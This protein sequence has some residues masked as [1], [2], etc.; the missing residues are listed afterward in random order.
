ME[1]VLSTLEKFYQTVQEKKLTPDEASELVDE[2]CRDKPLSPYSFVDNNLYSWSIQL[3]DNEDPET[4]E[5][6]KGLESQK[7]EYVPFK[8]TMTFRLL[9]VPSEQLLSVITSSKDKFTDPWTD[10]IPSLNSET[11]KPILSACALQ[12]GS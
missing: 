9:S 10:L 5:G 7:A 11:F 3:V 4:Q 2:W 8:E 12:L 6:P 1:V